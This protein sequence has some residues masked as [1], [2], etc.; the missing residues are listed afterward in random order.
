MTSPAPSTPARGHKPQPMSREWNWHP[1]LPLFGAPFW[2]W[3]VRPLASL[4]WL[5]SAYF[6]LSDRALY[7]LFALGVAC[8][9]QPVTAAQAVLSPDW[10]AVVLVRNYLAVLVV[11][12][13][14]HWWFYV[15][16]GQGDE[17]KYDPRAML[18]DNQRLFKFGRQ[19]RDNMFYSLAS[20]VPVASAYEVGVRWM[21]ANGIIDMM[22]ADTNPV[23]FVVLFPLMTVWQ[24]CHFYIIHR[25]LH[26]RPLYRHIHALHHRAVNPG[27]WSGISM[28]P[29]EH[30]AYFSTQ[31][32]F[33]LIASH[34]A[35]MLFLLYWQMLG[36]PSGH[37]GYD[38]VRIRGVRVLAVGGFF[39]QLHHRHFECNYGG[40]EMP[41]DVWMK[42]HHD[43]SEQATRETRLRMRERRRA[44]A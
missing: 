16:R 36:A 5:V 43:G 31:A 30:L 39:H 11:A 7:L 14:L 24:S 12:G 15:F 37:A 22:T 25:A 13:G 1:D 9:F 18:E 40:T 20:G 38:A 42:T 32:I 4:K 28:H 27:P 23:W 29:L 3:P 35:H 33:L 41:W 34:P 44:G 2:D 6:P 19:T 10:I 26:W 8:I 21:Y 17:E